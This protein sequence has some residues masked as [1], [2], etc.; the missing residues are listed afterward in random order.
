MAKAATKARLRPVD[1]KP[2]RRGHRTEIGP[3]IDNVGDE[4]QRDQ[5]I[6]DRRRIVAAHISREALTQ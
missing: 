2:Q 1:Q 5:R 6:D 4:E 3:D